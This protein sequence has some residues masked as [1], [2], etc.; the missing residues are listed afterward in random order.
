MDIKQIREDELENLLELYKYLHSEE[1][2]TA[3][4]NK[5]KMIWKEI[6]NNSSIKIFVI[7]AN[8]KI[9]SS[10]VLYIF[11]NLTRDARPHALIENVI[12]HPN[13]R[14]HGYAKSL[15]NFVINYSKKK[16]CYKIMLLSSKNRIEA[17][18]LYENVGFDKDKK[19]GFSL[20]FD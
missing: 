7:E 12:T 15:L 16:N 14:R 8:N 9:V 4:N 18:K 13:Y 3:P 20:Y 6:Q 11:P 17:H 2:Y 19:Y 10:C 1:N 5:I